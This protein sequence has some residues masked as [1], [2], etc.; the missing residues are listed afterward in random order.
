MKAYIAV[1]VDADDA[2]YNA[3]AIVVAATEAE[4]LTKC[5]ALAKALPEADAALVDSC[6]TM[7]ELQEYVMELE[8]DGDGC[9]GNFFIHTHEEDI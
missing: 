3:P 5:K 9:T 8:Y 6:P 7:D 4:R 2:K 1:L